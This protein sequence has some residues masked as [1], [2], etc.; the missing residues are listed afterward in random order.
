M[1]CGG[2]VTALG[3][4][5]VVGMTE[6]Y[7]DVASVKQRMDVWV[8]REGAQG[9]KGQVAIGRKTVARSTPT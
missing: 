5:I 3:A 4:M 8:E 2:G 9:K 6:M 7:E 1:L